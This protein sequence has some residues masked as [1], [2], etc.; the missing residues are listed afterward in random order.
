MSK[1]DEIHALVDTNLDD[2]FLELSKIFT[3]KDIQY[4]DLINAHINQANN[5]SLTDYR[6]RLKSFILFEKDYINEIYRDSLSIDKKDELS[7]DLIYEMLCRLNFK[8]QVKYFN[9]MCKCKKSLIPFV[10]RANDDFGQNWLCTRLINRYGANTHEPIPVDLEA[11]GYDLQQLIEY[12]IKKI[13]ELKE[14]AWQKWQNRLSRFTVEEKIEQSKRELVRLLYEKTKTA[15]QFVIIK[16]AFTHIDPKSD[17]FLHFCNLLIDL[18][19]WIERYDEADYKCILIFVEKRPDKYTC[20][21]YLCTHTHDSLAAKQML[22]K[23][24][25]KIVGLQEIKEFTESDIREWLEDSDLHD[26]I[27]DK[28]LSYNKPFTQ[29]IAKKHPEQVIRD[30]CNELGVTFLNKW[31][32]H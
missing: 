15:T 20:Q 11:T 24:Q 14:G 7:E 31:I 4:R 21:E 32:K 1:A 28:L 16:N 30:I 25:L 29:L 22:D 13:L 2:A 19:Y 8:Q 5:F 17:K 18:N 23:E 9:L 27:R 26:D 10:V 3:K 6:S 12:L